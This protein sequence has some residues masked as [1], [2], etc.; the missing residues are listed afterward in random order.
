MDYLPTKILGN[1]HTDPQL[2]S[3]KN[4]KNACGVE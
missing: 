1:V 4:E 2:H 3:S